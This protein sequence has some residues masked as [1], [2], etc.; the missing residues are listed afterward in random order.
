MSFC[1]KCKTKTTTLDALKLTTRNNRRISKGE[2]A[3]C[4]K[5]KTSLIGAGF[6]LNNAVNNLP[7]TP[8]C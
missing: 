5:T 8:V 1:V 6:S 2:C 7:I 3:V 4:R